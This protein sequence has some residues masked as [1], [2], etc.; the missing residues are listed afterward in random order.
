[1]GTFKLGTL[2]DGRLRVRVPFDVEASIE[3]GVHTAEV[4][5]ICEWGAGKTHSEAIADLQ[6]DIVEAYFFLEEKQDSLG[7]GLQ[8]EWRILQEKITKATS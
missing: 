3:D 2:S 6:R 1:M 8:L 7:P 4:F 5:E